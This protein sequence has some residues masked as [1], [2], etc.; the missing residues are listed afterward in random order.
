MCLVK[1]SLNEEFYVMLYLLDDAAS[2]IHMS[3]FQCC[4][5]GHV[6]SSWAILH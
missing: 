4:H 2:D 1:T 6:R 5:Y 3:Y